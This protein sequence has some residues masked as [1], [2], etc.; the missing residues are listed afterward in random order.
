MAGRVEKV[1]LPQKSTPSK[2]ITN[3]HILSLLSAG[4][5]STTLSNYFV[6]IHSGSQ[7]THVQRKALSWTSYQR[8]SQSWLVYPH[9]AFNSSSVHW[10]SVLPITK[11]ISWELKCFLDKNLK[12]SKKTGIESGQMILGFVFGYDKNDRSTSIWDQ[13]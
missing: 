1:S 5:D 12:L 3:K 9:H 4:C 2:H 8:I 10:V 11:K 6:I 13:E 7:Q